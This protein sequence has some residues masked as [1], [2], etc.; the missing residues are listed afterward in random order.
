MSGQDTGKGFQ[1]HFFTGIFN[2]S[3]KNCA[4]C[5]QELLPSVSFVVSAM[6]RNAEILLKRFLSP[7]SS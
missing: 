1:T 3:L 6:I 2:V 5:E 7:N 4:G